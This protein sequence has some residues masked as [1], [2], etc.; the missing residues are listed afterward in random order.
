MSDQFLG[1]IRMLSWNYPPKYWAFCDGAT[2]AINQNQA[3]FALLGTVFGGNGVTNYQ[4][5][6]MRAR[7]P[8][9]MGRA[10]GTQGA[11][12]GTPNVTLGASQ[13][14]SHTHQLMGTK[15]VG[16][17]GTLAVGS[18]VGSFDQGYQTASPPNNPGSTTFPD[19]DVAK[20]G[21]NQPHENRQP[22]LCINFGIALSG[23]FPSRN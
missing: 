11:V 19:A 6:D 21:G 16:A 15:T 17:T 10:G 9:G 8:M 14:P 13:V 4:L 23:I 3:L 20:S 12:V 7:V 2:L 18:W 22:Y 5:P 1:E